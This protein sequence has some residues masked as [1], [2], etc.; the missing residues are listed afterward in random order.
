MVERLNSE[1]LQIMQCR[2]L[3]FTHTVWRVFH[4]LLLPHSNLWDFCLYVGCFNLWQLPWETKYCLSQRHRATMQ[5][6]GLRKTRHRT[7]L[8]V[9]ACV[10]LRVAEDEAAGEWLHECMWLIF[11]SWFKRKEQTLYI[12]AF[13]Q[14]LLMLKIVAL[15]LWFLSETWLVCIFK[16][17]IWVFFISFFNTWN[18][19]QQF[20]SFITK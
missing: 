18:S 2:Y 11:D 14:Y 20:D 12:S 13:Q 4:S 10:R 15:D 6:C 16:T 17:S 1:I 8:C 3:R 5:S 7:P 19:I 9:P